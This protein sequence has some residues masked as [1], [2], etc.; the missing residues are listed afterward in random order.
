[1]IADRDYDGR[2]YRDALTERGITPCIPS[3]RSRKLP[4]P[5]DWNL[6]RQRQRIESAFGH[7]KNWRRIATRYDRCAQTFQS[8]ICLAITGT[9][10][11]K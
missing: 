11:L 7:I 8:A 1:M 3:T 5:Y 4:L 6:Y 9:F 2:R 10:W